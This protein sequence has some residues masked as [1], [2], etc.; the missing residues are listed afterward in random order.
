MDR[1][2]EIRCK[3]GRARL[4]LGCAKPGLFREAAKRYPRFARKVEG[5]G[6]ASPGC[7]RRPRSATLGSAAKLKERG[8]VLTLGVGPGAPRVGPRSHGAKWQKWPRGEFQFS[9]VRFFEFSIFQFVDVFNVSIVQ[10]FN[11]LN[12]SFFSYHFSIFDFRL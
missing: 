11:L 7:L 1:Q 6:C 3:V 4:S 8:K 2:D 5:E 12:F 9:I 10:F